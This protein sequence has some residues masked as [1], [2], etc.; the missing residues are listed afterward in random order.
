[1]ANYN[2]TNMKYY[3]LTGLLCFLIFIG[4][5]LSQP[6]EVS[7]RDTTID[8]GI[9][10]S[11]CTWFNPPGS[12]TG[13]KLYLE[14][15]FNANVLNI[16]TVHYKDINPFVDSVSVEI[17]LSDLNN[18][19]LKISFDEKGNLGLAGL[20]LFVEGLAGADTVTMLTPTKIVI[21]DIEIKDVIYKAGKITVKSP[22]VIPGITEGLGQNRPNPFSDWTTF[23]FGL[24]KDSEI[25]FSVYGI[26]GRKLFDD[27]NINKI[28]RVQ[29]INEQG[30]QLQDYEGITFKRGNYTLSL[31]PYSWELSSGTYFILMKTNSGV[32]KTNF[33]Y[34]K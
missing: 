20:C 4:E 12:Y 5:A 6:L 1:M 16:D 27:D 34:I 3:I 9:R 21:D 33:M 23:P 18:A 30:E 8:R 28:F 22:S 17:D 25:S 15:T 11:I 14:Y 31:Q 29:I 10:S 7:I 19:I 2:L 13:G 24:N 32:Y 26:S